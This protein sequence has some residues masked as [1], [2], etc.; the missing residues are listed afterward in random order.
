M[1]TFGISLVVITAAV[2]GLQWAAQTP[3]RALDG[4]DWLVGATYLAGLCVPL[5]SASMAALTFFAACE[6]VRN[7]RSAEAVAA[8]SLFIGI[9]ACQLWG[10]VAL[11]LFAL[12]ILGVDAA[13][14]ASLLDIIQ[15][16]GVRRTGNLI[17]TLHGQSLII[18]PACSSLSNIS[19]ALLCW[20]TIIRASRASWRKA[21]LSMVPLV[22]IGV[23]TLNVFRM[24]LMGI[25]RE[26]YFFMHGPAGTN[27]INS[28]ILIVAIAAAWRTLARVPA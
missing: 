13:L 6:G 1:N 18:L 14:V 23:A 12:P 19:Y 27:V 15:G 24:T 8:A 21:D 4:L 10:R 2:I 20:M 25:S 5:S 9:A 16:N 26:L 7:R 28:F 22:I 17:D 3:D 11:Q